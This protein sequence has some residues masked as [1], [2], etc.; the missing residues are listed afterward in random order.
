MADG[1]PAVTEFAFTPDTPKCPK[2]DGPM[3]QG[4][5]HLIGGQLLAYEAS[6]SPRGNPAYIRDARS[7]IACGYTELYTDPDELRCVLAGVKPPKR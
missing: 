4:N 2:C 1:I 7:C 5:V 6:G 3:D